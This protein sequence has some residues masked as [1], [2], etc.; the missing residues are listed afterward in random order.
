[1]DNE[2]H[3]TPN[4]E[5]P[6]DQPEETTPQAT[7]EAP[8]STP[9]PEAPENTPE[10]ESPA[11]PEAQAPQQT[12]A[13]P[14]PPHAPVHNRLYRRPEGKVIAGVCSGLAAYWG[15]DPVALRV[16]FVLLT[17]FSG[18]LGLLAYGI[19]WLVMPMARP[20]QVMPQRPP[21]ESAAASRWI[22]IGAIVLGAL[23]LSRGFFRIHGGV[24]W[25]LILIGVGLA[26]WGGREFGG[27]SHHPMPPAPPAPPAPPGGP[28]A[29]ASSTAQFSATTPYQNPSDQNPSAQDPPATPPPPAWPGGSASAVPTT[30]LDPP[31]SYQRD[32]RQHRDVERDRRRAQRR[33]PSILGRLVIGASALA[34]GVGL[35][36]DNLG[37]VS[38]TPKGIFAVLLGIV[39][40][41]LLIGT[42]FG[43]ARWLIWPGA[44][45]ALLL[46]TT[47]AVPFTP[48][49]GF[50]D[51][52]WQPTSFKALQQDNEYKHS[53]GEVVLDLTKL[54]FG[55]K[56][57][58]VDADLGFGEL[59]IVV[60]ND[61][62]VLVE[63]HV[64]GGEMTIFG[65]GT[66]GWDVGDI[67]Y[68]RGEPH[69]GP[70]RLETNVIFGTLTVQ[71][72][73]ADYVPP[74]PRHGPG[75]MRIRGRIDD[76]IRGVIDNRN[77]GF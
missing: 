54:N 18:G 35:L 76:R 63:A 34:I 32:R 16:A 41:G 46:A 75:A 47:A 2:Q 27:R 70:L 62:N 39:G 49:G 4:H 69:V 23:I 33:E 51:V 67:V 77:G 12:W 5:T 30:P 65:K 52:V 7:P 13:P 25:G 53:A 6:G 9:E 74:A 72:G 28:Y 43:R 10:P 60:P 21:H 48:T 36:L 20:G 58:T 40:L 17:I 56:D 22:A 19:A 45:L 50:G 42:W 44:G 55:T 3:E 8:E 37:V 1:M 73:D 68:S 31:S 11:A 15:V 71:R 57:Q 59:L 29:A 38:M 14:P 66:D 61:V 26:V 64:Q 24:F